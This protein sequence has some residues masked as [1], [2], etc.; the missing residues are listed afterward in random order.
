MRITPTTKPQNLENALLEALRA[1]HHDTP[2][3]LLDFLLLVRTA[4]V[5]LAGSE[6]PDPRLVTNTVLLKAFE[7]LETQD[8][9]G[10]RLLR[11]RFLNRK[12]IRET[13]HTL[14]L[15]EDQTKKRQRQ[16]LSGLAGTLLEQENALRATQARLF[17]GHLPPPTYAQLFGVE[18]VLGALTEKLV[19]QEPPWIIALTGLGGLGKTALAHTLARTVVH[20]FGQAHV[21]WVRAEAEGLPEVPP[22]TTF[23]LWLNQTAAY[24]GIPAGPPSVRLRQVRELLKQ[25]PYLFIIDNLEAEAATTYLLEHLHGMAEPS[26]FLLTTRIPPIGQDGVY[27]QRLAEL[28]FEAAC[29]LLEHQAQ[30]VGL[31]PHALTDPQEAQAIYALTGGNPLAL[32]LVVGL[33]TVLPLSQVLSDLRHS[34]PG[35]VEDMY[36]H[37]YWKAWQILSPEAQTLLQAMPLVGDHGA[38]P[39]HLQAISKLS[40][41]QFWPAVQALAARSLLEVQGTPTARRYGLHPLTRTFLQTEIIRWPPAHG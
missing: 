13:A 15:S 30:R 35:A 22:E 27:T 16:A 17:E 39:D 28:D 40:D 2:R 20:D 3:H 41:T 32:K 24:L 11:E 34:R 14:Q 7:Q 26:K 19:A 18:A 29:A 12:S 21:R 9:S 37:I 38:L 33:V 1:W 31:E 4:R 36:Q 5:D 23:E 8:G 6:R 10:G 25:T